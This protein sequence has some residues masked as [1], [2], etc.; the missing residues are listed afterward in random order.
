MFAA[1][2]PW[3]HVAAGANKGTANAIDATWNATIKD[4]TLGKADPR[5]PAPPQS[6]LK[7]CNVTGVMARISF[8]AL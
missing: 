2:S 5:R 3:K 8:T 4:L 6:T 1:V 7:D